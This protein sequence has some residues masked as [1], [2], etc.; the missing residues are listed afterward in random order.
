MK[1]A[2]S[3]VARNDFADPIEE[4]TLTPLQLY[5]RNNFDRLIRVISRNQT[6]G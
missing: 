3:C 5:F 2:Q 6:I 4:L 1:F